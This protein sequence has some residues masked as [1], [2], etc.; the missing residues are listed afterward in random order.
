M[1]NSTIIEHKVD[2]DCCLPTEVLEAPRNAECPHSGTVSGKIQRLTVEH[3]V[4]PELKGSISDSQYYYCDASDCPVVYFTQDGSGTFTKGDLQV[5]V[6]NKD[7]G[8]D[9]N[10]CYCFDWTRER[11]RDQ[12]KTA[13]SSTALD[14]IREKVN[15]D[16]CVCEMK[17]PK[18]VCCLGDIQNF[19]KEIA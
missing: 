7:M 1:V 3:L 4:K 9:V 10:V 18:G 11:I 17:N 6:F 13:G 5:A 15:A 12:I 19:L 2:C 14:E 8:K 16:N